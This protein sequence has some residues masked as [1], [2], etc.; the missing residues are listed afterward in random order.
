MNNGMVSIYIT[1]YFWLVSKN[2]LYIELFA[3][4]ITLVCITGA[5]FLPESPKFYLS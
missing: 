1:L 5:F 3:G 2:W 4:A